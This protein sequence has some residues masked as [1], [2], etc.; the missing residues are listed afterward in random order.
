MSVSGD[1]ARRH[2]RYFLNWARAAA[3]VHLGADVDMTRIEE[4]RAAAREAGRRYSVVSYLLYAAGRIVARHPEARAMARGVLRPRTA[5]LPDVAA[6]LALDRRTEGGERVVLTAVLPRMDVASLTEIQDLVDL[7]RESDPHDLPG[8]AAVRLLSQLPPPVGELVFRLG[9]RSPGARAQRL[10]TFA[11]SSLGHRVVDVF[12][13]YGGTAV[14]FCAGRVADR[15]VVRGGRVVAAPVMSLGLTFDHRVLDGAA[16]ADV[17]DGVVKRLEG[18]H[19]DLS[20]TR[21]EPR[22][23]A[24]IRPAR[25][26]DRPGGPLGT[27]P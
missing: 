17:L 25:S 8:A 9:V 10:G 1:R 14:T 5:A 7:C 4:H 19:G 3:P 18:W 26:G 22:D 13:S 15:A 11:V 27:S 21:G 6:K 23:G 12:H 2:T 24:G 20:G 16:A